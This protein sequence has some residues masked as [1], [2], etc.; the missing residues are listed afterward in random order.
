VTL[1]I[2]DG[3]VHTIGN[4]ETGQLANEVVLWRGE[5]TAGTY[6]FVCV[7]ALAVATE[8]IPRVVPLQ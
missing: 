2:D 1:Q 8:A 5:D 7:D 3:A 4:A 6:G